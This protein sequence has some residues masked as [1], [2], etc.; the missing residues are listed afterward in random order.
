MSLGSPRHARHTAFAAVLFV[1]LVLAAP[2]H[3][4][5]AAA[6]TNTVAPVLSGVAKRGEVLNVTRGQ[7]T[8]APTVFTYQW[9]RDMGIGYLTIYGATA[10]TYTLT[11]SDVN[12]RLRVIVTARN[13]Y[14]TSAPVTSNAAGP[15]IT[16]PPVNSA[17]PTVSGTAQRGGT[18]IAS[19]GT[20]AGVGNSYRYQWQ[21]LDRK[22]TRLNSSH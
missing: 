11:Q 2:A 16:N 18:L 17:R 3:A 22:S 14:G 8:D 7:W 19:A 13:P 20:W 1:L 9:Q 12:A 15:I 4:W 10:S 6:P 21:R 5:A